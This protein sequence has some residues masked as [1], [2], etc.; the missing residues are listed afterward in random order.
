MRKKVEYKWIALSCTS[1]GALFSILSSTTLII[2]L[3]EI[4]K[5]LKTSM[6]LIMWIVMIYMFV[7][8]IFVPLVG[9]LADMIGRKKLYV[10]GFIVF[11]LGSLL[12]GLSRSGWQLLSFRFVQSVG[13]VLLES[14]SVPIVADAFPKRELGKA[15]GINGMIISVAFVIGPI[16]GGAIMP[17]GWRFIFFINI[18]IGIIGTI[19]A[20]IQLKEL[21]ILPKHQKF[22]FK[23]TILFSVGILAFL[24]AL[25]FGGS[26]GWLSIITIILFALAVLLIT[27]F[28]FVENKVDHPMLDLRLFK[29]RLLAF[30]YI[31]NLLNGMARGSVTFLL[32]FYFQGI[33]GLD[34]IVSGMLLAPFAAAMMIMSPISGWLSDRFGSR[35]L[36]SIGL[37]ISAIGLLGMVRIKAATTILELIIWM[38]VMGIGTGMFFAPNTNSIMSAVPVERRGI[39]AGVRIMM[40]NAGNIISIGLALAIL[41][42]SISQEAIQALFVGTQVGSHGIAVS[43]FVSGLRIAFAISFVFSLI[44]AIISYL[45]GGKPEWQNDAVADS[46]KGK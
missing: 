29:S 22:D 25:T 27:L 26:I 15:L 32:V 43:E 24:L 19:W 45:R 2:A 4:M 33:K 9:R 5:D 11:M 28:I 10:S 42:S 21:N 1:I 6:A 41:S 3:P 14:S 12:C 18:P 8:T 20:W 35:Q 46:E 13:G 23:G 30:A 36:S 44:A 37:L 7:L 39:A 17:I 34:P 16:L 31:S 38:I 40:Q